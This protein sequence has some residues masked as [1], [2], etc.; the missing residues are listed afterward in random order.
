MQQ[1]KI[2]R[3]SH[4]HTINYSSVTT[5]HTRTVLPVVVYQYQARGVASELVFELVMGHYEFFIF[6]YGYDGAKKNSSLW[7]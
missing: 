5:L 2:F 3:L 6:M 1:S 4:L 7:S